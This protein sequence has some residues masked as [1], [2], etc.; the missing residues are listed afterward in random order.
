MSDSQP[1]VYSALPTRRSQ[2]IHPPPRL[3]ITHRGVGIPSSPVTSG[4][5]SSGVTRLSS[6]LSQPRS[7]YGSISTLATSSNAATLDTSSAEWYEDD[8]MMHHDHV[9]QQRDENDVVGMGMSVGMDMMSVENDMAEEVRLPVST[10]PKGRY[11]LNDFSLMRTVGTGSFGRVHLV[12]SKHN[13]RFYAIKVLNKD[14]VVRTKQVQHTNNERALLEVTMH[15]FI[16]NLWGTFQDSRNLYMVMDFVPGGELFT[17]LRRSNRFPDPVAKFYAAEVAL[18]LN[19]LHTMNIIYRDLKPENVLLNHDGH[20]KI[21]DFGF[22]KLCPNMT[23]TLCGTPDYLAPEIVQQQRYNKSVD[24]YALGVLIFEMLSGLPP[25]HQPVP[26]PVLLYERIAAGPGHIHWPAFHPDAKDLIVKLM[27]PDPSRRY[28]NLQHGAGDV[29]AHAW[30]R[31]VDWAK[32]KA[33]EIGAPYIPRIEGD[34]DASAFEHYP[35]G[36]EVATYGR[37]GE[38]PWGKLFPDFEYMPL[39]S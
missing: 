7:R 19:H 28:G 39:V 24:W 11:S 36:D 4:E 22:A 37:E 20:I 21:A 14:K 8:K 33:R 13:L 31:E 29:F 17:L 27:E 23:W 18:A 5:S 25:Y 30:F 6:S 10:R 16:V 26:N 35:E 3:S 38:D 2:P 9:H 12:R 32:L 15:P 34:G 1:A